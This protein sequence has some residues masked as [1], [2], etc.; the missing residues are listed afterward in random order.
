MP[1]EKNS[2]F[3]SG[4]TLAS[5]LLLFL[6]CA[7]SAT[8][9][10]CLRSSTTLFLWGDKQGLANPFGQQEDQFDHKGGFL[11]GNAVSTDHTGVVDKKILKVGPIIKTMSG[12][13]F[14]FQ[15]TYRNRTLYVGFSSVPPAYPDTTFCTPS[16]F[17]KTA[18]IHLH[19]PKS[20]VLCTI[21]QTFACAEH[22]DLVARLMPTAMGPQKYQNKTQKN[23]KMLFP[24]QLFLYFFF[25]YMPRYRLGY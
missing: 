3:F 20:H 15:R 4:Y 10:S 24:W 22:F 8:K 5:T 9:I 18:S 6:K 23:E 16:S 21:M 17:L 7:R 2:D 14:R 25:L 11:D 19:T 13:L 1:S 12:F